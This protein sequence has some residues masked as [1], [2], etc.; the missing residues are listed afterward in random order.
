M[1]M[2]LLSLLLI[3]SM[4]CASTQPEVV[5]S[6][7][8]S[9]EITANQLLNDYQVFNASYQAYQ[10]S[11]EDL[12]AIKLLQGKSIMVLFGTWCHDSDREVPKLLKLLDL[13]DVNLAKLSLHGVNYN[14]QEPTNLHK[15]F[16]MLYTPTII[17]LDGKQELGRIVE[18]PQISLAADLAAILAK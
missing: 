2:L 9:G 14:K 16:D 13:S 4:G 17:L 6:G 10:P 15:Q 5:D 3:G 18:K 12:A 1:K 11:A 8:Y 7:P